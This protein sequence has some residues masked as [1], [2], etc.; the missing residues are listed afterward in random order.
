[1]VNQEENQIEICDGKLQGDVNKNV[2]DAFKF[3]QEHSLIGNMEVIINLLEIFHSSG[4][5]GYTVCN[6]FGPKKTGKKTL[7]VHFANLL[8]IKQLFSRIIVK[9]VRSSDS[10][11]EIIEK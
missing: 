2:I 9:R 11:A 1:M 3:K 4:G 7:A 8:V 5:K 10:I 6:I